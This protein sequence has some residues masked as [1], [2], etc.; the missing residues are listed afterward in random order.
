MPLGPPLRSE[1]GPS[2]PPERPRWPLFAYPRASWTYY[3]HGKLL[4]TG[5]SFSAHRPL[6]CGRS[7]IPVSNLTIRFRVDTKNVK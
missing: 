5:T 7:V 2:R 3:A 4:Y 6:A 1:W